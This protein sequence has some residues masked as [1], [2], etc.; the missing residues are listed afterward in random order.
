MKTQ[1]QKNARFRELLDNPGLIHVPVCYDVF[2]ARICEQAGF[3]IV[4]MGGNGTMASHIGWPDMSIACG[5]E[6]YGRAR[7]ISQRIDI[8]LYC[9]SDAGY[10]GLVNVMRTVRE[11]EAAG[12]SGIHLEDQVQEKKRCGQIQGVEVIDRDE[13]VEKVKIALKSRKDPNFIIVA[14]TDCME[15][16]LG[17]DEAI[18]RCKMFADAGA[19]VVFPCCVWDESDMRKVCKELDG[20]HI[21]ADIA[22]LDR[23]HCYGDK[24]LS[25]MGFKIATHGVSTIYGVGGF[26]R[27]FYRSLKETGNVM[28]FFDRMMTYEEYNG[29]LG[30]DEVLNIRQLLD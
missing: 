16:G 29:A 3:D 26:L 25:E 17:V 10:G 18:K 1:A 6:M 23:E 7:Q 28:D 12:A 15:A 24:E 5:S 30:I 2:S 20:L 13:A 14:R 27:D 9:D 21:V 11:Y 4:A 8:P 22:E 19:D